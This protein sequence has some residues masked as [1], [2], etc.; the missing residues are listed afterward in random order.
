MNAIRLLLLLT[1]LLAAGCKTVY[2]PAKPGDISLPTVEY[3]K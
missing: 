1:M 3:S 2:E